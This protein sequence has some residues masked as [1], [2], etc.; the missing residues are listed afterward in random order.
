[1]KKIQFI[2]LEVKEL[3]EFSMTNLSQT[4]LGCRKEYTTCI[5]WSLADITSAGGLNMLVEAT[6]KF[7]QI[8]DKLINFYQ[9]IPT[10]FI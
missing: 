4:L 8:D 7:Q 6:W 10:Q 5:I 1:M 9:T 3:K 2:Y